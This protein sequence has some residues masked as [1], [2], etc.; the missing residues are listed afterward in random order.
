MDRSP[1]NLLSV[2]AVLMGLIGLCGSWPLSVSAQ[3][4]GWCEEKYIVRE[5]DVAR[6]VRL[7]AIAIKG[8]DVYIAY[9]QRNVKL[10]ISRDRG[11]TWS[12]PLSIGTEYGVCSAPA[13][14]VV[15]GKVVIVWPA[16]V[17]V[18]SLTA[19]QLFAVESSDSGKTWSQPRRITTQSRDDTFSPRFLVMGNQ[20]MLIWLETPLAET[21]GKISTAQRPNISPETVESLFDTGLEGGGTVRAQRRQVRS[22]FYSTTYNSQS[23][24]FAPAVSIDEIFSQRLP[25]VFVLYGP[26]QDQVFLTVNQNT[27]IKTYLTRDGGRTWSP[28]FQDRESFDSGIQLDLQYIENQRCSTWIQWKPYQQMP[29]NFQTGA[30]KNL[31]QLSPPHFVRSIPRL[32][33]SDG[34]YHVVWEAGQQRES[35]LTYMRTDKTP[36][37]SKIVQPQSGD[38]LERN[39]TVG[40]V[41]GDNISATDRLVY[42]FK[43]E[44]KQPWSKLQS[45]TTTT[46]KTPPDGEYVFQL[47]AEDVAGNIQEPVT[48]FKF[49][50]F[51]SAPETQITKAPPADQPL[52]ARSVE[53]QFS[54]EDNT[55]PPSQLLFSTQ[56]DNNPWSEFAKGTSYTFNNLSN[57]KHILRVRARDSRGNISPKPAEGSVTIKVGL[58]L[59]LDASP[60]LNSNAE[61]MTFAWTA[62]NDK[63]EA[64][65]LQSFY[66]LDNGKAESLQNTKTVE[67][68]SLPE[69]R[70]TIE[71]WGR[72][73]SGDET[74]KTTYKWL[75]DR[76]PPD[77]RAAFT[78]NYSGG[79]FPIVSLEATDP[80]LPGG[81]QSVTPT[82]FEYR[83]NDGAWTAFSHLGGN[84]SVGNPLAFYSWGYILQVRAIDA[85][86]NIDP[87][88]MTVDLRIFVR[89]NP[90]IFYSEVGVIAIVIFYVLK[91][92]L[93]RGGGGRRRVSAP[94]PSS[95]FAATEETKSP[96]SALGDESESTSSFNSSSFTFNDDNKKNDDPFA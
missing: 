85:A 75:V 53:V 34:I 82:R 30:G 49:N 57:G 88:P 3:T 25:H 28:N 93:F 94:A 27:D 39:V 83:I 72:D 79:K 87:T 60:P 63:G 24:S 6:R 92:L 50:T 44:E 42:A 22:K 64:V 43:Y 84:W 78:K 10:V 47:R 56:T 32:S 80:D 16:Y 66:K 20:A 40:W 7:P 73:A 65:E 81:V 21:L 4:K 70:H 55:D 74:P 13:I 71:I 35:W 54:G 59:V 41:G 51:K 26:I 91:A 18:E 15:G 38:I 58:E 29:V 48:Q 67:L 33:Y 86:G 46:F 62:K 9:L 68:D 11:K 90:Y 19:Y 95:T 96:R 37:T 52:N 1:R 5:N 31:V 12:Q 23:G 76:T 45:E 61:K 77:T 17:E 2:A 69:G 36:P 89:T 14:A 8:D